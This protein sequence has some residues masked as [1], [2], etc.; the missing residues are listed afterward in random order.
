[1][2]KQHRIVASVCPYCE[3]DQLKDETDY[4]RDVIDEQ[5]K[6]VSILR[7]ALDSIANC[8]YKNATDFQEWAKE[9]LKKQGGY[10]C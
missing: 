9:A 3:I 5:A 7:E 2:C 6:E 10:E 4:L 8:N 1:M